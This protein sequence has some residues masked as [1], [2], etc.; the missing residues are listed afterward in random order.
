MKIYLWQQSKTQ[1][2][3]CIR[4][5]KQFCFN[6][7]NYVVVTT[8]YLQNHFAAITNFFSQCINAKYV[9]TLCLKTFK[10]RIIQFD[11]NFSIHI[12]FHLILHLRLKT[13]L[14]SKLFFIFSGSEYLF[15]SSFLSPEIFQSVRSRFTNIF[16][17]RFYVVCSMG[18]YNDLRFGCDALVSGFRSSQWNSLFN[19]SL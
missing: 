13:L 7:K 19:L 11:E 17:S 3:I 1:S 14:L 12:P 9:F 5:T 6:H 8:N 16:N 10:V 4:W 2:N 18:G 15:C